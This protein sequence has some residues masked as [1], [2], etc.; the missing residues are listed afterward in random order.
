MPGARTVVPA[1]RGLVRAAAV[2][3]WARLRW[4]RRAPSVLG[5]ALR[6]NGTSPWGLCQFC[7]SLMRAWRPQGLAAGGGAELGAEDLLEPPR[8]D[9]GR[10]LLLRAAEQTGEGS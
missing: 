10:R 6:G 9:Q 7:G 8:E 2:R 3:C 1:R 5:A 4:C